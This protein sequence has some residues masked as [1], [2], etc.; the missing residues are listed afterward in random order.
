MNETGLLGAGCWGL[1]VKERQTANTKSR[2]HGLLRTSGSLL[3]SLL[4][5]PQVSSPPAHFLWGEIVPRGATRIGR[6]WASCRE[7]LRHFATGKK[8][9]PA[10]R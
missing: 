9:L 2:F 10:F 3:P 8:V 6:T 4:P 1:G 7:E 5:Q